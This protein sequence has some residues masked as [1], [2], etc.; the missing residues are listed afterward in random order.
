[1][2]R[3]RANNA[4]GGG[5]GG[6]K[7]ADG[8]FHVNDAIQS[9]AT[10]TVNYAND[11]F[12]PFTASKLFVYKLKTGATSGNWDNLDQAYFC[13][14]DLNQSAQYRIYR[15]SSANYLLL[16]SLPHSESNFTGI[17]E[18]NSSGFKF[19][20]NTNSYGGVFKYIAIE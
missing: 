19:R 11:G 18:V 9:N 12:E 3:I 7:T 5:G 8:S 15:V 1:M 17:I 6:S 14:T 4:S 10:V 16:D 13:D 2:A 20:A